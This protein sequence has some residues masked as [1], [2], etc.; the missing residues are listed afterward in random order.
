MP[1]D[2]QYAGGRALVQTVEAAGVEI[3]CET[4]VWGAFAPD[5]ITLLSGGT[6]YIIRPRRL[7]LATGA[8][9]RGVPVPGWTLPGVISL[10]GATNLLSLAI[11]TANRSSLA[12]SYF[13]QATLLRQLGQF[14]K[15]ATV[16]TNNLADTTPPEHRRLSLLR[17]PQPAHFI[18]QAEPHQRATRTFGAID[19]RRWGDRRLCHRSHAIE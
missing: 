4:E 18:R 9:E 11:A 5:E 13:F 16:H 17:Y 1:R 14:E 6:D 8:Y 3:M 12:D 10:A 7:I 19:Q 2:R 15:A